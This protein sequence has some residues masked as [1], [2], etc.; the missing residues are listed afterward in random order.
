MILWVQRETYLAIE[1]I[2]IVLND[3]LWSII[4]VNNQWKDVILFSKTFRE[5]WQKRAIKSPQRR[6]LMDNDSRITEIVVYLYKYSSDNHLICVGWYSVF[7]L[8]WTQSGNSII[9]PGGGV[10][11]WTLG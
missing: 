5:G 4:G 9:E 7:S 11:P 8:T 3:S 10:T 2:I 6:T 1:L